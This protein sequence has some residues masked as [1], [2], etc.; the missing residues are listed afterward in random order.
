MAVNYT[1]SIWTLVTSSTNVPPFDNTLY[2]LR[3]TID[4]TSHTQPGNPYLYPVNLSIGQ[5]LYTIFTAPSGATEIQRL[6]VSMSFEQDY[7]SYGCAGL[8]P[9]VVVAHLNSGSCAASGSAIWN[10]VFSLNVY[11]QAIDSNNNYYYGDVEIFNGQSSSAAQCVDVAYGYS[12]VSTTAEIVNNADLNY[13]VDPCSTCGGTDQ[14]YFDND[15]AV[16]VPASVTSSTYPAEI[17]V[18]SG[19]NYAI[20]ISSSVDGQIAN[21]DT[22]IGWI[23][24]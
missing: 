17:I 16:V 8:N 13:V 24:T 1:A 12:L 23:G 7:Y 4:N 21:V 18:I 15:Y 6:C 20:K 5:N 11:W 14:V 2:T 10:G 22:A 9:W 19:S 3:G